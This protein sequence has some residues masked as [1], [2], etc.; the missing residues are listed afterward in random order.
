MVDKIISQ[1]SIEDRLFGIESRLEEIR[2]SQDMKGEFAQTRILIRQ[3][4]KLLIKI[5]GKIS[6]RG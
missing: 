3:L 2:Q 4:E 5:D 1:D 6:K